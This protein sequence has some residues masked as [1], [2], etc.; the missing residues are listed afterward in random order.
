M[1]S[2]DAPHAP[3]HPRPLQRE[4][5]LEAAL[6]SAPLPTPSL[7]T[8]PSSRLPRG[9]RPALETLRCRRRP[10]PLLKLPWGFWE[11][12]PWESLVSHVPTSACASQSRGPVL[13]PQDE[14]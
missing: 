7:P 3:L 1:V 14:C 8:F 9:G 5:A 12:D 13:T 10:Q 2:A 11:N 4:G 6:A